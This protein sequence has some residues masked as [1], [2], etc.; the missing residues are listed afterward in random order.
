MLVLTRRTGQSIVIDNNIQVTVVGVQGKKIRLG[1]TA[2]DYMR[3]D[4]LE[5][6]EKRHD[7]DDE[8]ATISGSNA[9]PEMP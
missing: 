5:V 4:R 9:Q 3:V 7:L 1:I 6:H 8:P 2:P